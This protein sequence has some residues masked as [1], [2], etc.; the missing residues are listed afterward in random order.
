MLAP[1]SHLVP[2]NTCLS[3]L[4]TAGTYFVL[5]ISFDMIKKFATTSNYLEFANNCPSLVC[6]RKEFVY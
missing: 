4:R 3:F 5:R 1:P 6:A 2:L